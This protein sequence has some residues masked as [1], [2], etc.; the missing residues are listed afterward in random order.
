MA[1]GRPPKFGRP[2]TLVAL[3]LP[4]DAVEF[5]Q[6]TDPDVG[7]AIVKLVDRLRGRDEAE[8]G[9]SGEPPDVDLLPIGHGQS[10]IVVREDAFDDLPDVKLVSLGQGRAFLAFAPDTTIATLELALIDRL[11]GESLDPTHRARLARFRHVLRDWRHDRRLTFS[12]RSIVIVERPE[13][14]RPRGPRR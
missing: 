6:Q 4:Q 14:V 8:A 3:T 11:E 2:S 9:G 1:R 12:T 10:L 7:W 13:P 5:L